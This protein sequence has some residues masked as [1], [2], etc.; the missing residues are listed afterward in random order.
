MGKKREVVR[1]LAGFPTRDGAG[2]KLRRM[3]GHEETE[4]FDPFLMLDLFRSTDPKDYMSGFPW[5][6]HR[7]IETV[8]FM[9]AGSVKH[10]DSLGHSGAISGGDVQWM[11]AG[12]GIIHQEMPL[13]RPEN[14][15]LQLWVNLP[16]SLKMTAPR[17]QDVPAESIPTV[18]E[19][20]CRIRV[21][22]GRRGATT[23]PV[24]GIEAG[25]EFLDVTLDPGA[26]CEVPVDATSTCFV[27]T[28]T[29]S[30]IIASEVGGTEEIQAERVLL[31]GEGDGVGLRAGSAGARVLLVSGRPLHEP[32][33]WGGPIVMNT[34]AELKK[35]F[36]ELEDG[37]FLKHS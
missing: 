8:T 5:H 9:V 25:P 33:A 35:A 19:P 37:T 10:G 22:A 11:T 29:G 28:I 1:I 23:G 18:T 21:I 26:T 32:V 17:Y 31:F 13:Q 3:I 7:G 2:V 24:V 12:S 36:Q 4:A 15:G 34:K 16:A 30:L 6:P 27:V 14:W 20:G